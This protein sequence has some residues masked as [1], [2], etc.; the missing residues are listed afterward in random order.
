MNIQLFK[1]NIKTSALWLVSPLLLGG[2][3]G[4]LLSS[5]SSNE[6]AFFTVSENDAPRILNTDFPDGGFS[7]NRDQNLKFEV[8]VTPADMTTVKWITDNKEY[9]GC[10]IDEPFEAGDYTLKILAV[11]TKGKETSRTMSLKVKPLDNDPQP[12]I[13]I[14]ERVVKAGTQVQLHG[15][16]MKNISQ[17]VINGKWIDAPYDEAKGCIVYT[18]PADLPDG[19]YRISVVDKYSVSYGGNLLTV[20]S[21]P[22]FTKASYAGMSQGSF[23]MEGLCLSTVATITIG[24]KA[25]TITEKSDDK[26]TL[27][28][29]ELEPGDYE[30]KGT[31]A[32]GEPVHFFKDNAM[33]DAALFIVSTEEVVWS[34][35]HAVSWELPDGNP[36][37][38]WGFISQ[39]DFAKYQIG[40]TLTFSLKYDA[41]AT[42]H[43]YQFD[44]WEWASLPGQQKTDITGDTDVAIEITQDL[45]DAVAA[46]GLRIHGHGFSVVRVTYK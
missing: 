37:K 38:E 26:I 41:S 24:G 28:A 16:N 42:Y 20:V 9:V 5:C 36:N 43:Q 32:S 22:I 19:S 12:G 8:L 2:V 13:D 46:K 18:V 34:G 45:K 40:H 23:T 35:D 1:K 7:I 17:I 21:N 3:G 30:L 39:E 25:C 33:A 15:T 4:G 10:N 14:T 11:T 29:P 31:T 27:T 6:D 44:N